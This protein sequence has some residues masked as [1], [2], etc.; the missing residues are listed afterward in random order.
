VQNQFAT[1]DDDSETHHIYSGK[2]KLNELIDFVAPFALSA[3]D[4][5]E[6]RVISSKTATSMNQ[7]KDP[8]GY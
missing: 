7:A 1:P 4:K 5:K 6:E 3:S 2:M 8:S